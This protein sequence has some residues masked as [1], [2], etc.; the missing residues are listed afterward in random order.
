MKKDIRED[1]WHDLKG[2]ESKSIQL[3]TDKNM[4]LNF[5]WFMNCDNFKPYVQKPLS[6][7]ASPEKEKVRK[8]H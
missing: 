7:R 6:V 1:K 8:V 2:D 3:L 4:K 5:R